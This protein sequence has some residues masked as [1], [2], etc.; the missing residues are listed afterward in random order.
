MSEQKITIITSKTNTIITIISCVLIIGLLVL[1]FFAWKNTK[2]ENEQLRSQITEFKALTETL[3]RGS[4]TWATKKDLE[5]QLKNLLTK[6]ELAA[7]NK[8]LREIGASL[9][10]VG[11]TVGRVERRVA[12][13]EASD[14]QIPN[15]GG[16]IEC[17]SG[18]LID[19]H[20]YTRNTQVKELVDANVA[21][22]ALV[23]FD[24]SSATPWDYETYEK[25][26]KLTTIV[27]KRDSG[28]MVLDYKLTYS[29][30]E[31][32]T[33]EYPIKI[34]SSDHLQVKNKNKM[35]WVNPTLDISVFGGGT[36][37]Q[38]APGPGRP[39]PFSAG[40]DLGLNISSYGETK[41]DSSFKFF[42]VGVGY[43]IERQSAHLSVAP[44][45]YNV[46]KPLPLIT[47]LYVGPTL[48]VDTAGGIT[49]NLGV[50]LQL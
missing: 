31:K 50:G 47:N 1:G 14:S 43:N 7:L 44:I 42:R 2:K 22:V 29:V 46:G 8:D 23:K 36:V 15:P 5:E 4:T 9:I 38:F 39:S 33:K 17:P 34:V 12:K 40:V 3:V 27:G 13:L 24:A 48:A 30:P 41:V 45:T 16:G 37:S 11:N 6:E 20:E 28:Q 49:L 35:F 19:T 18:G 10:V 32:G 25:E 26:Y 21:P